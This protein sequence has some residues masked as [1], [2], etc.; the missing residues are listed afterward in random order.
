MDKVDQHGTAVLAHR[1]VDKNNA[2]A[3][4]VGTYIHRGISIQYFLNYFR[5][6]I[7]FPVKHVFSLTVINSHIQSLSLEVRVCFL[8]FIQT[9]GGLLQVMVCAC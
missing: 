4:K 8:L 2:V 6:I 1:T 3:S 9:Y 5:Q 7:A